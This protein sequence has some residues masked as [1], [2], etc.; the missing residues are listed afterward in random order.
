MKIINQ[1]FALTIL[2]TGCIRPN[3]LPS[4]NLTVIECTAIN[5]LTGEP[6]PNKNIKIKECEWRFGKPVTSMNCFGSDSIWANES[7]FFEYSFFH[8]AGNSYFLSANPFP[9]SF[10]MKDI[11]LKGGTFFKGKLQM[12]Q[13]KPL[14]KIK[15]TVKD[16]SHFVDVQFKSSY[17]CTETIKGNRFIKRDVS[18]GFDTILNFLVI[19]FDT[20]KIK[21]DQIKVEGDLRINETREVFIEDSQVEIEF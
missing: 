5:E 19:P 9:D 4:G 18:S 21:F 3:P 6:I 17:E 8:D 10:C 7:G 1:L 12:K 20:V 11:H 13:L 2:L 14:L 15:L 16:S